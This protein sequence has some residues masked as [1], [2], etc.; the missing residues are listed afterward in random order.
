MKQTNY[1]RSLVS[2]LYRGSCVSVN[3]QTC[4]SKF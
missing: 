4:W 1:I 3:Y 2:Y